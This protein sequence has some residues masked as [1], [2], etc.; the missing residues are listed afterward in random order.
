MAAWNAAFTPANLL[1]DDQSFVWLEAHAVLPLPLKPTLL[2]TDS[3]VLIDEKAVS[4]EHPETS[5]LRERMEAFLR[6]ILPRYDRAMFAWKSAF[7]RRLY[8]AE[9]DRRQ[10]LSSHESLQ[11]PGEL[12]SEVAQA[13]PNDYKLVLDQLSWALRDAHDRTAAWNNAFVRCELRAWKEFFDT[14]EKYPLSG[15]QREAIVHE[16]D[17]TLVVAG[18]GSGKTSAIAGKV[19]YLLRRGFASTEEILLLAFT[20]KAANELEERIERLFRVPVKVR[21]FHALGLEIIGAATGR[22][23]A[24][25]REAEDEKA[26]QATFKGLV[27][28][29][30]ASDRVFAATFAALQVYHRVPYRSAWDFANAGDYYAYLK[31]TETISLKGERMRSQEEVEV[32]NFLT[33]N[34]VRYEYERPYEIDTRTPS[35]RQY[36]PDFF[37][38]DHRIYI[39][40][41]AVDEAGSPPPWFTTRDR[42]RYVE[43]LEWKRRTHQDNR[44]TLIE[45][46]SWQRRQGK[47][48]QALQTALERA[49]VK[50]CP[51]PGEKVLADLNAA[52][53][54]DP[55]YELLATF[56]SLFKSGGH[57]LGEVESRVPGGPGR[58]RFTLF[59]RV[60]VAVFERYTALLASRKEIDFDD[61]IVLATEHV[62][63]GRYRGGFRYIVVDEFQDIARGRAKLI[64]GLRSQVDDCKLF[65]VGDDWQSIYRFT[66]SDLSLMTRFADHF[67]PTRQTALETTFRFPDR[68]ARFSSTFVLKNKAQIRKSLLTP[69]RDDRPP[70]K[71][72]LTEGEEDSLPGVLGDIARERRQERTTVFVL[73]RYRYQAKGE[74]YQRQLRLDYPTLDVRF[75]T[76]H[77][78]KGLEADHVIVDNLRCGRYGFPTEIV[79]DPVLSLVLAHPD[80]HEHGEERRLFYV[81]ITRSR[82]RVSL[83]ADAARRSC[84]VEEI[85][86]DNAYEKEVA[87]QEGRLA[88]GCPSCGRGTL[89]ERNSSN[90]VF[91]SCSNF[92]FCSY[93]EEA[94]P[95][96]RKGRVRRHPNLTTTCE[97]CGRQGRVCPACRKGLFILKNGPYGRF[98]G[99]NLYKAEV[100]SCS[101]TENIASCEG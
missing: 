88:E 79:D 98:Y 51:V 90:G 46:Y 7:C 19:G 10:W 70:V 2:T 92:P 55:F 97:V 99:C 22:K 69:R 35:R 62:R 28:D 57:T 85:L 61:M 13:L 96:C 27:E 83:I 75:L 41:F 26:K 8:V 47:L 4:T 25:W 52:G 12:D 91:F 49:G 30:V 1:S 6:S 67:G 77:S 64:R 11:A 44:T 34:G 32:A 45:T 82:H 76:A 17:A 94:C 36:K 59:L 20:R 33:L 50:L 73:N 24:L 60:F 31:S 78:S 18:A 63:S 87:G 15:E 14:F 53:R 95:E 16:E 80:A 86:A 101:H 48:Q 40:H 89:L 21:T 74:D 23:P 29:L 42:Q 72:Y 9:S 68:L 71:V 54:I 5:R 93:T 43:D 100:N 84:F 65:C 81:A 3:S 58:E 38:P 39:E 66:G 56:L 37:L